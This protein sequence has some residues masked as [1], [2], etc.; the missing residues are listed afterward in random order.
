MGGEN[1]RPGG[2]SA[3]LGIP[4]VSARSPSDA[5][6]QTS[7]AMPSRLI[8]A[9]RIPSALEQPEVAREVVVELVVALQELGVRLAVQEAHGRALLGHVLGELGLGGRLGA[10]GLELRDGV[11]RCALRA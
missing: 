10:R 4:R 6:R 7:P 9:A 1:A 3:G 8:T 2:A 5:T 11:G